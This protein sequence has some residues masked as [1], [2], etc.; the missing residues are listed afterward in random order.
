MVEYEL[1]RADL[2]QR[3]GPRGVVIISWGLMIGVPSARYRVG[4]HMEFSAAEEQFCM[5]RF[6]LFC[7]PA[8]L[9]D[10]CGVCDAWR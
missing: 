2:Q 8:L 1:G 4:L 5:I 6:V 7:A 9:Q 3:L 10:I